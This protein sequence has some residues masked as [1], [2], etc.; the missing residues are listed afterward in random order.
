MAEKRL[1]DADKLKT[2]IRAESWVQERKV[3]IALDFIDIII[4]EQPTVDA[5]EVVRCRDCKHWDSETWFCDIHSAFGH[6]D[7][8]W[9]MFSEEDFCS[10]GER[11]SNA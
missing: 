4:S 3:Q 9:N 8:D 6:Y 7:L 5:L 11:R 10:C 2:A 1:I